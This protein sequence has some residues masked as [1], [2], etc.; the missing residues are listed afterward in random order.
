MKING[1]EVLNVQK[2]M[3]RVP[4]INNG[5]TYLTVGRGLN[6]LEANLKGYLVCSGIRS[7]QN[8]YLILTFLE[9]NGDDYVCFSSSI[10]HKFASENFPESINCFGKTYKTGYLITKQLAK[11]KFFK[12]TDDWFKQDAFLEHESIYVPM[13]CLLGLYDTVRRISYVNEN[14][15]PE[16]LGVYNTVKNKY[17]SFIDK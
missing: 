12:K 11:A 5:E 7:I 4:K 8:D 16:E 14:L 2:E 17:V 13:P 9:A 6:Y 15:E 3:F 1:F 10:Q